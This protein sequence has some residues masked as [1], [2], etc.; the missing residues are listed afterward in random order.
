[1]AQST[2]DGIVIPMPL[3]VPHTPEI[4]DPPTAAQPAYAGRKVA[5]Y[6][7]F[8]NVIVSR[9]G[10]VHGKDSWQTAAKTGTPAERKA[11]YRA[12]RLDIQA[13]VS[14]FAGARIVVHRA[15]S[16]WSSPWS[17]GYAT[18]IQRHAIDAIQ[19]FPVAGAKNGADMRLTID[20]VED[21]HAH[22]EITDVVVVSGDSDFMPLVQHCRRQ[23]RFFTVIGSRG[24]TSRQL[25]AVADHT[26]FYDDLAPVAL[27]DTPG[28]D[29][30]NGG[31]A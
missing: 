13:V 17:S 2:T 22:G 16:D 7:D 21:L 27:C 24:H 18:P 11:R 4:P 12:A 3:P 20:A 15:Y 14:V 23:S 5:I 25:A 8:T 9:Y 29:Q 19:V 26:I 31:A 28:V 30:R 10:A 1:M 6:W